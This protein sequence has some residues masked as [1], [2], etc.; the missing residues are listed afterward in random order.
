MSGSVRGRSLEKES[1]GKRSTHGSPCILRPPLEQKKMCFI[2][3]VT[4]IG[5]LGAKSSG[6]YMHV[7]MKGGRTIKGYKV[8]ILLAYAVVLF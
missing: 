1:A 3:Q 2:L 5:N 8:E 7:I 6:T 4:W